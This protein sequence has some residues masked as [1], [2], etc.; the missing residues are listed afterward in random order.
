MLLG[1]CHL[2]GHVTGNLSFI[3]SCYCKSITFALKTLPAGSMTVKH[4][5]FVVFIV[6]IAFDV[7]VYIAVVAVDVVFPSSLMFLFFVC[8]FLFRFVSFCF[9]R[10]NFIR[11]NFFIWSFLVLVKLFFSFFIVPCEF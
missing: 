2:V 3:L 10:K 7:V 1:I 9:F 5:F 11:K 8:G 6:S 4:E